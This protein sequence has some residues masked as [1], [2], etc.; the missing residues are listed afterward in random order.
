VASSDQAARGWAERWEA[1]ARTLAVPGRA[2]QEHAYLKSDLEFIGMRVPDVRKLVKHHLAA[3][4]D[5]DHD[6][7]IAIV[8]AL[9][10]SDIYE[11][12][13]AAVEALGARPKLVEAGDFP[14]IERMLRES[15]TWALVDGLAAETVGRLRE[16]DADVRAELDRW[17]TDDDFWIRRSALLA[18]LGALRGGEGDFDT[19][20]R[21]ADAMLDEREFFIRKAIGWVLRETARKREQ[22]VVDWI[23]PRT[24]RASGVT[25]RE[26][27]RHLP[28]ETADWLMTAYRERRPAT[29]G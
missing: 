23:A 3:T 9:W 10:D 22:L 14:L 26:V 18:H 28:K 13:A 15:G 27:T 2:E 11:R 19:F 21:Y 24:G 20:A 4:E 29:E 6:R 12:R 5:L 7:L 17:A 1:E 25:M 16:A 8:E